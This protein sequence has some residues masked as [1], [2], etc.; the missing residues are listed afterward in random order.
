M[1]ER[2]K[3]LVLA[4]DT[5]YPIRAGG[6]MRMASLLPALAEH[7]AVHVVCMG[8]PI[9]EATAAWAREL[10]ITIEALPSP[11]NGLMRENF[12][13]LRTVLT[14][15]NLRFQRED[16][17]RLDE[18]FQK[19]G[20]DLVWL[21]TPY[22]VR[23][24]VDWVRQVPVVVDYWGTSEGLQRICRISR[25]WKRLPAWARWQLARC[26]EKRFVPKLSAIVCV[27]E[28][29]GAFFRRIAPALPVAAVPIAAVDAC[30]RTPPP[31][32]ADPAET[33]VLTGDMSFRPNV[34]A[35][36]YFAREI[37]PVIR[38]SVP[39]ARIVFAGRSPLP[40]V[41]ALSKLPGVMVTG[42]VPD[43]SDVI[44]KADL[45]VLPMRLGSGFRTKLCDVFPLGVPIVTTSI[46]AEGLALLHEEN[47][48]I[49]DS[50]AEFADACIRLLNSDEE[51]RRLG[52]ALRETAMATY[53][54]E[55]VSR[56]VQ[57]IVEETLKNAT[58][59][60]GRPIWAPVSVHPPPAAPGAS[61]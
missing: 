53:S 26:G 31:Q 22:P 16:K 9:E 7:A 14:F 37:F 54:Q 43:L 40:E 20:P 10:G 35:A 42:A 32:Y 33:M 23:Y 59:R 15:T 3:I 36:V 8:P 55:A 57:S 19:H 52:H 58:G 17:R 51:R 2:P 60:R 48:L 45:Y 24:A 25:G 6:Q 34:D 44:A 5:P 39:A 30:K 11:R 21:E 47:C 61:P 12:E 1:T 56:R 13:R 41:M 49:A 27:S 46:G 38:S 50:T 18:L 28:L 4:P 29:D